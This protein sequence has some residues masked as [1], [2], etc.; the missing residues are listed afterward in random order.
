MIKQAKCLCSLLLAFFGMIVGTSAFGD[1]YRAPDKAIKQLVS[2]APTPT[3]VMHGSSGWIALLHYEQLISDQRLWA[4]RLG[5]AGM[6]INPKSRIV[7]TKQLIK[8]IEF[9]NINSPDKRFRWKPKNDSRFAYLAFSPDGTK[10][11][12]VQ[13]SHSKPSSLWVFDIVDRKGHM[14]GDQVNPAWGSPCQWESNDALICL[15]P[16]EGRDGVTR[17]N[18][19]TPLVLQHSGKPEP[20][21][22][23]SFLL[24]SE[25]DDDVFEDYFS[26]RLMRFGHNIKPSTIGVDEG[27]ITHFS[28]SPDSQFMSLRRIERP[29]SR[30]T[31]AT[32]FPSRVEV[33]NVNKKSMVYRSVAMG[34]AVDQERESDLIVDPKSIQ[35][36]PRLPVTAGFVV[37]DHSAEVKEYQWRSVTAPRYKDHQLV[38]RHPYPIKQFGW[39]SEGTPLFVAGAEK[40]GTQE[41]YSVVN[42]KKRLLWRGQLKNPY[43]N[44]GTALR[45]G[46]G[47]GPILEHKNHIFVSVSGLSDTGLQP[48]MYSVNLLTGEQEPIYQSQNG[49]YEEILAFVDVDSRTFVSAVESET[50]PMQLLMRKPGNEQMLYQSK[51]P[52]PQLKQ[53]TRKLI[54]YKR[55]DGVELNATLYLPN[56]AKSPLPTLVWIYPRDF[57]DADLAEQFNIRPFRY[58]KIKGPS[59]VSAVLSGYAV[60]VNPSVPIIQGKEF[61][62]DS[63]LEQLSTSAEA[64]V[65]YLVNSGISDPKRIA[66]GGRSYGAFASTN[67]LIHTNL[68]AS[69]IAMSGAYNRTLTPFGFQHERRSFWEATEFY[70]KISPFFGANKINKPLLL[71]HGGDD[72]NPGTPK[73]QA[74]RLFHA[75]VGEGKTVR[76]VELPGEEHVYR[77]EKTTLHATWEMINWLDNTLVQ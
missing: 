28:L 35:W 5:L 30:L 4:P 68:F 63:Y 16:T 51:D 3:P 52:Y 46:G 56:N 18:P 9:F 34:Y 47:S 26:S 8:N 66:I 33:W 50:M 27:V 42:E 64:L 72:P 38:V 49:N 39:T 59:A 40:E 70:T 54:T 62:D 25:E 57:D 24:E 14:L 11:S 13:V 22:T 67:L 19:N 6:R 7:G 60:V 21:R 12:A 10:V 36:H 29:Y 32:L 76:Y 2:A 17:A 58:H 41:I 61:G 53:S 65:G 44:P 43:D 1:V 48:V 20:V 23:Y 73:I 75:L 31:K 69:G 77:G 55:K 37:T 71:V 74:K 15:V 45:A